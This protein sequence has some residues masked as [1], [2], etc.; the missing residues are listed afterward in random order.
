M[1]QHLFV[2]GT[3][4]DD[5]RNQMFRL[6]AEHG[7]FAGR[8][9]VRGRLFDLGE[10]PG[11]V[12]SNDNHFVTGELYSVEAERAAE[13]WNALDRYEG[14]S[15]DDP[16]PHEYRRTL[17]PAQL[18]DG[19]TVQAWAYV[20]NDLPAGAASIPGGDYLLWRRPLHRT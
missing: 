6:V 11:L 2:Y 9:R 10:Y 15:E 7:R 3:L 20:L 14:C 16:Q 13:M 12:P 18:N 4:R 8:A 19:D 5:P 17:V 1:N